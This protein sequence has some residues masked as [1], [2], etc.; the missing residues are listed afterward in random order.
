MTFQNFWQGADTEANAS[1]SLHP[2]QASF[3]AH[4]RLASVKKV[5]SKCV[6]ECVGV[7]VWFGVCV[8]HASASVWVYGCAVVRL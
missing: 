4:P 3:A 7:C 5:C 1:V 6:C 2:A 8:S